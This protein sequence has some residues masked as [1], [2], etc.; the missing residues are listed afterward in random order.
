MDKGLDKIALSLFAMAG[1]LLVWRW[2][3]AFFWVD[4]ANCGLLAQAVLDGRWPI[5]VYGVHYMGALDGYI[6][7]PLLTLTG[8]SSLIWNFW[9]VFYYLLTMIALYRSLKLVNARA[10]VLVGLLYVAIPPAE[11]MFHAGQ[12]LTHYSLCLLLGSL[13]I[14]LSLV[15]WRAQ[16]WPMW[17]TFLWGLLAGLGYWANNQTAVVIAPCG[18][19]LVLFRI[20]RIRFGNALS[21]LVGLAA[22]VWPVIY[23]KLMYGALDQPR[24]DKVFSPD[25]FAGNWPLFAQNAMPQVLGINLTPE[26]KNLQSPWFWIYL[27]FAAFT[28]LCMLLL[29]WRARNKQGRYSLMLWGVALCNIGILLVSWFGN[30]LMFKDFRYLLPL[31]LVLPF[32]WAAAADTIKTRWAPLAIACLLLLVHLGGYGNYRGGFVLDQGGFCF[33]QEPKYFEAIGK[34]RSAGVAG[35][36]VH[37]SREWAF[38]SG[39]DPQFC[40]SK[41]ERR[42]FAASQVDAMDNPAFLMPIEEELAFAGVRSRKLAMPKKIRFQIMGPAFLDMALPY[43]GRLLLDRSA[44]KSVSQGGGGDGA[45]SLFDGDLTSGVAAGS[46]PVTVDLGASG[47]ICALA[48]IPA[49]Y[50]ESPREVRVELLDEQGKAVLERNWKS[51]LGPL[52]WSG[53]HLF[54]KYRYPRLEA[55]FTPLEAR[56]IRISGIAGKFGGVEAAV[57]ELAVWAPDQAPPAQ[58]WSDSA[59]LLLA[60]LGLE[61]IRKVYGDAWVSA[62]LHQNAPGQY[63]TLMANWSTD[64]FGHC[65]PPVEQPVLI[66]P[67]PGTALAVERGQADQAARA[68]R[69]W[70]CAYRVKAAGRLI[71]FLLDGINQGPPLDIKAVSASATPQAAAALAHGNSALWSSGMPQ[72]PGA[73]L[74]LDLGGKNEIARLAIYN[75]DF[76]MDY[77]R[78]LRFEVSDDGRTWAPARARLSGPMIM[79]GP[80][81]AMGKSNHSQYDF[82]PGVAGRY[83]R[84][85]LDGETKVFHWTVQKLE[86]WA[87]LR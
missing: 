13:L 25:W 69:N 72:R 79:S 87:P 31:Y 22:G 10:G 85:V 61:S 27:A 16:R 43:K 28:M 38:L 6:A 32:A 80:L 37:Q 78:G 9:P 2:A 65:V 47:K 15:M 74:S 1:I 44:W 12:A 26:Q 76:L 54:N 55:H 57:R 81:V 53:P 83:L 3:L 56:F 17:Q 5:Y 21:G 8:P 14:W 60:P 63:W 34:L 62:Y 49:N 33:T 82:E 50:W 45:V 24:A 4:Q 39:G 59:R 40:K 19:F 73:S 51:D 35:V 64:N 20:R 46:G 48:L 18:L 11:L 84:I 41:F 75:Q 77:P 29:L 52:Y 67:G 58:G 23:Y 36:Y 66:D 68:L 30:N 70:G 86:L 71:L 42:I 7:A